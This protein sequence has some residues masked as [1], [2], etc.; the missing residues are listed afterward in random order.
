MN[1]KNKIANL[2]YQLVI[3]KVQLLSLLFLDI[4]IHIYYSL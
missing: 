1:N 2:G 3:I 4:C